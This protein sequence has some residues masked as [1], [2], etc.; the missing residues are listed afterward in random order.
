MDMPQPRRP[1]RASTRTTKKSNAAAQNSA[2]S[3]R[4][5]RPAAG[6]AGTGTGRGRNYISQTEVPRHSIEEALRVARAISD[7]YGKAPTRPLD[8][9]AAMGMQ[10]TSG[11]FRVL[12]G[13]SI[14]YGFT[15]G[16]SQADEISL[17]A[18]GRRVVAPTAENDDVVA[19][20][21][22]LLRPRIPRDFLQ[23]Y[24][25]SKW[26]KEEIGINVL[27]DMGCPAALSEKTLRLI[28]DSAEAL[29]LLTDING[30]KHVNL[31]GAVPAPAADT[32]PD[33]VIVGD[34]GGGDDGG[35][36]G[37]GGE[38]LDETPVGGKAELDVNR[39]VFISHGKN[40]KIVQQ[41]KEILEFGGY[42]PVVTVEKESVSKPVPEKV[43]DDM[44]EC[45]A[46]II[47]VGA[48]MKLM[49]DKG[50]EHVMLNPN[51]L[52]E[53]GA[54][55]MRYKGNFILL[56]EEGTTL[57]SNLQGLYEVRYSGVELDYPATMKLL[58]AFNDFKTT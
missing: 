56:V 42:E 51:V 46:A 47:H 26:P 58:K 7:N 16:G 23:K 12:T 27:E 55:M 40:T 45:A 5:T 21:E 57:P 9:A 8:V 37:G 34:D 24:D 29:G 30:V 54:A 31:K 1:K 44:R 28:R 18:L 17:T 41:I 49:D 32:G 3:T 25:G 52:I 22:A 19:K 53:I 4:R 2:T 13:A 36:G 43:L 48:E 11:G 20:R 39:K 15:E 50:N 6:K 14:A 38:V 10:P 35:G 33:E